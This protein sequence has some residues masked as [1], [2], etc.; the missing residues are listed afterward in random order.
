MGLLNGLSPSRA[1]AAAAGLLDPHGATPQDLAAGPKVADAPLQA[2]DSPLAG[3]PQHQWRGSYWI[4]LG[5][6]AVTGRLTP[7]SD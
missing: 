5:R 4:D 1:R 7:T 2:A 3:G 6:G